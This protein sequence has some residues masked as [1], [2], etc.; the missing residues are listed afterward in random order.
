MENVKKGPEFT[1]AEERILFLNVDILPSFSH[2]W[3]QFYVQYRLY[4]INS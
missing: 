1:T 4:A 3:L 2:E